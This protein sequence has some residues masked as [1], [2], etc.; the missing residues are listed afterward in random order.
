[1]KAKDL[2]NRVK[3]A[4]KAAYAEFMNK[5]E[6]GFAAYADKGKYEG[7]FV[8]EVGKV[9]TPDDLKGFL[10]ADGF[11]VYSLKERV[12]ASNGTFV[13]EMSWAENAKESEVFE[14]EDE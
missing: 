11:T 8:V 13:L 5:Y 9:M 12:G 2:V 4:K 3:S 14:N 10:A 1:M 7:E 6:E